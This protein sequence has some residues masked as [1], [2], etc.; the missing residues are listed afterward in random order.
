MTWT[1]CAIEASKRGASMTASNYSVSTGWYGHRKGNNAM[2]GRWS[3]YQQAAI[4]SDKACILGRDSRS[5]TRGAQLNSSIDY[6]GHR[7]RYQDYGTTYF[8]ECFLYAANAGANI[9]TPYTIGRNTG[10]NYWVMSTHMC[11]TYA[12]IT[13]NG[14]NISH[15][16]IGGNQRS[17][18]RSCMVGY[19]DY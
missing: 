13:N 1:E 9:I 8:D 11:N 17:S 10:D 14:T 18:R 3:T 4:N 7:W 5:N 16:N 12:W 6:D 15:D 2:T 19:I